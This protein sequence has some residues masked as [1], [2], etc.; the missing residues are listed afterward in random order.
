M[1]SLKKTQ[2]ENGKDIF[3][4]H[5]AFVLETVCM[6]GVWNCDVVSVM[7]RLFI[8]FVMFAINIFNMLQMLFLCV[9]EFS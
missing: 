1:D 9:C 3:Y 7:Y 8:L 2:P 5:F 6:S 4:H